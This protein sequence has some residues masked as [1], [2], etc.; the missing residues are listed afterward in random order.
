MTWFRNPIAKPSPPETPLGM[1]IFELQI[2]VTYQLHRIKN[3]WKASESVLPAYRRQRVMDSIQIALRSHKAAQ[4]Y[5]ENNDYHEAKRLME[6]TYRTL[7]YV[8]FH[9]EKVISEKQR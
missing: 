9:L 4:K 5:L 7:S 2:R 6:A 1:N 8:I 3:L